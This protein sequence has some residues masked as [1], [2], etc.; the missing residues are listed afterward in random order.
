MIERPGIAS[1]PLEL[2]L[3]IDTTRVHGGARLTVYRNG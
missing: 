3:C 1:E 2:P